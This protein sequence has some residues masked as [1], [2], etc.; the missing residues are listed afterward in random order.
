M[1]TPEGQQAKMDA[2]AKAVGA[3]VGAWKSGMK[4]GDNEGGRMRSGLGRWV[5]DGG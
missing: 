4:K 1:E 5:E 2:E 3:T